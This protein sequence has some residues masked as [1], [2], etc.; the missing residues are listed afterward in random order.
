IAQVRGIAGLVWTLGMPF[1][2]S[3]ERGADTPLYVALA[4]EL[5]GKSGKYFKGR[6]EIRPNEQALDRGA[7]TWLWAETE[8][9]VGSDGTG[10]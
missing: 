1:M 7:V 3:P 5:A 4:P 9:L 10:P 6:A 8:R 2:L